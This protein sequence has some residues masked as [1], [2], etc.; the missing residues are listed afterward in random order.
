MLFNN[1]AVKQEGVA[2]P[3]RL[4]HHLRALKNSNWT[5]PEERIAR[6]MAVSFILELGALIA[7]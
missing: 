5:Q 4:E 6:C 2:I 7:E 3:E 1:L